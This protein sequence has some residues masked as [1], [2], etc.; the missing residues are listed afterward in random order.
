[1]TRRQIPRTWDETVVSILADFYLHVS[2]HRCGQEGVK[3]FPRSFELYFLA[4]RIWF[5]GPWHSS[6]M[7][8]NFHVRWTLSTEVSMPLSCLSALQTWFSALTLIPDFFSS[9]WRRPGHLATTY[10]CYRTSELRNVL[11]CRFFVVHEICREPLNGFAP[12]SHGRRDSMV[13]RS[14]GFEGQGQRSSLPGTKTAFFDPLGCLRAVCLVKLLSSLVVFV[15]TWNISGTTERICD[16]WEEAR[17]KRK[18]QERN[19][20][21]KI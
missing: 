18:K 1:M 12:N 14:N 3:I 17:K 9:L 8:L 7:L 21:C 20:C 6:I 11:F 15:C 4:D 19:H 13:P 2:S 16:R 5:P 10:F